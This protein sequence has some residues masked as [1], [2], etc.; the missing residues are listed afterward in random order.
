MPA[1]EQKWLTRG[2]LVLVVAFSPCVAALAAMSKVANAAPPPSI[3]S[4]DGSLWFADNAAERILRV[5]P[6]GQTAAYAIAGGASALA[7]GPDG[8][9][10]F[11]QYA[12]DKIGRI[13]ADGALTLYAIPTVASGPSSIAAGPDGNIW[14]TQRLGNRIGRINTSGLIDEF[15]IPSANSLPGG[16]AV[17][18]DGAL[19]FVQEG[20]GKIGRITIAGAIT[21]APTSA[22]GPLAKREAATGGA[23][24]AGDTPLDPQANPQLF[25]ADGSVSITPATVRVGDTVTYSA[26]LSDPATTCVNGTLTVLGTQDFQRFEELGR[27]E[28]TNL[29]TPINV[30]VPITFPAQGRFTV[31]ATLLVTNTTT[32]IQIFPTIDQDVGGALAGGGGG[33]CALQARGGN[34]ASLALLLLGVLL[35]MLQRGRR[36]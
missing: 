32:P 7:A 25:W 9:L 28:I 21:E 12:A 6:S 16:I 24:Q 5:T 33:G 26:V 4:S 10:W 35:A 14:F 3:T 31:N 17:G 20:T 19:W 13:A 15:P 22:R 29:R 8:S 34:D 36:V 30:A 11:T 18:L 2:I 23:C 27:I 1:A